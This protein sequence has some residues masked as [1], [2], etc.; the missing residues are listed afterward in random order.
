MNTLHSVAFRAQKNAA[1]RLV[2]QY[3]SI[4]PGT[5]VSRSDLEK[6]ALRLVKKEN[7]C[8]VYPE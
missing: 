6:A 1:L 8:H 5:T 4:F 2:R 7:M 3:L